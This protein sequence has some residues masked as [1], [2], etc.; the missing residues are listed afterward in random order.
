MNEQPIET[1]V[2]VRE[3]GGAIDR[4]L[5]VDELKQRLEFVQ[6][7]MG[8]VMKEGQDYGKVPGCGDKPG[9]FQ[10]GAQ[11]LGMTFQLTDE[12]KSEKV[13]DHPNF[14][15][16]YS[17]VVSVKSS[18]GRT[19]DGVGTCSTMEAKYRYKSASLKCPLCGKETVFKSKKP[20]EGWYCWS[21]KGGCSAQ[22][23]PNAESIKSQSPGRVE[24]DNPPDFWNTVRKM[25]FKRGFV[26]AM[27]NATNTSELWS[28]DLEDIAA[29]Q[30]TVEAEVVEHTP[31]QQT[32]KIKSA[33]MPLPE[34]IKKLRAALGNREEYAVGYLRSF[35]VEGSDANASLM[36]NE[37]LES[38]NEQQVEWLSQNW[39]DFLKRLKEYIEEQTDDLPMVPVEA[40][41]PQPD[42]VDTEIGEEFKV[43]E[44]YIQASG[45]KPTKKGGNR[46]WFATNRELSGDK[47]KSVY[48]T[49]F[50]EKLAEAIAAIPEP[51]HIRAAYTED[52]WGMKLESV[53][54]I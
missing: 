40:V 10:P 47:S 14:H 32:V 28:Q 3:Q 46:W 50:D 33:D 6:Q 38:L 1:A 37:G 19:W 16:E 44:G 8:T 4:A 49:T 20:G 34:R 17:F 52:K 42:P 22:F 36:P 18:S 12:V 23:A 53:T 31:Q 39:P 51:K 26:H 15:R 35:T 27:I 25:A 7:I 41:A 29:N 11:K 9:L 21:K 5:T 30:G 13:V 45:C 43:L 2:V 48:L 24:H 54:A